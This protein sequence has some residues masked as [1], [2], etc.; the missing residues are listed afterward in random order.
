MKIRIEYLTIGLL[1]LVIILLIEVV[2]LRSVLISEQRMTQ[3]LSHQMSVN[4]AKII[5][6]SQD[7]AVANGRLNALATDIKA[8]HQV[9]KEIGLIPVKVRR[10][11]IKQIKKPVK[12]PQ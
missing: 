10:V 6:T 12:I 9:F 1:A 2:M 7:L 8:T 5:I 4:S 3:V 11:K